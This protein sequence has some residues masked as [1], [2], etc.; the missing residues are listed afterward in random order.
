LEMVDLLGRVVKVIADA[1]MGVA[2]LIPFANGFMTGDWIWIAIA[3]GQGFVAGVDLFW[4]FTG[5][6]TLLLLNVKVSG[7]SRGDDVLSRNPV[8]NAEAA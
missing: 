8:K 3:D 1:P 4:L 5:G 7:W 2:L 6:L